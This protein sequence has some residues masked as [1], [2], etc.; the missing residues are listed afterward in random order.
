MDPFG[1]H[2]RRRSGGRPGRRDF[3]STGTT[4]ANVRRGF[5]AENDR[6]RGGFANSS[7]HF[8]ATRHAVLRAGGASRGRETDGRRRVAGGIDQGDA[9]PHGWPHPDPVVEC[10]WATRLEIRGA[11]D[12]QR[13]G[14]STAGLVG[15]ARRKRVPPRRPDNGAGCDVSQTAGRG[16]APSGRGRW[17][18]RAGLAQ[19]YH[20]KPLVAAGRFLLVRQTA[21]FRATRAQKKL[22]CRLDSGRG[23]RFEQQGAPKRPPPAAVV[24][25]QVPRAAEIVVARFHAAMLGTEAVYGAPW[26][27]ATSGGMLAPP[28]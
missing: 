22:P 11:S 18:P 6:L 26:T 25:A 7:T 4:R 12:G 13:S 3:A 28:Q 15:S 8:S 27:K 17:C 1:R 21:G 10:A 19:T 9:R 14:V 20:G 23:L 16:T 5:G 2:A 24:R